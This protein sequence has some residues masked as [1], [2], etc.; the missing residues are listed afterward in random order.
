MWEPRR[1][2]TL[3]A[4]KAYYRDSFT[5]PLPLPVTYRAS[6]KAVFSLNFIENSVGT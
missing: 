4:S 6:G 1:L 5:L 3:R 2:T